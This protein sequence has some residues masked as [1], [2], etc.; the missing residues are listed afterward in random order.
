[1]PLFAPPPFTSFGPSRC[2]PGLD[3]TCVQVPAPSRIELHRAVQRECPMLPGVYGLVDAH[4][5]LLYVGKAKRLRVRLLGYFRR[6]GPEATKARNLLRRTRQIVWQLVPHDFLA[7]VREL[8]LIRR[9]RPRFNLMGQPRRRP[10][11]F[12]ALGRAPAPYLFLAAEIT[13]SMQAVFGPIPNHPTAR[14]AVQTLT[15]F[16]G[17]RDCPGPQTII[18]KEDRALFP[19][20][21]T[22]GCLRHEIG[23]CLGPC[24]A[25]CSRRQYGQQVRRVLAFLRGA[26]DEP[27]ERLTAAMQA[28]AAAAQ[29]ERAARLR[30]QLHSLNWLREALEQTS[31]A[32]AE[33]TGVYQLQGTAGPLWCLLE[34]GQI[35]GL[36]PAPHDRT[37]AAMAR[38]WLRQALRPPA[39]N[40]QPEEI[41]VTWLVAAWFRRYPE[42]KQHLRPVAELLSSG[43]SRARRALYH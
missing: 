2:V 25:R 13:A 36:W 35:R 43:A 24:A 26:A 29:F 28:A 31:R 4:G 19:A 14:T 23:L 37:S 20:E 38:D 7:L 18:F 3:E 32:Q 34:R 39:A 17:L 27:R 10:R 33:L 16:Y 5:E 11:L 6:R 1:M 22:P 9:W 8:E 30:D 40:A 42:Q 12:L 41:S 15:D 21:L